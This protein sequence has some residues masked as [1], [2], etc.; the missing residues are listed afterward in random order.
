[1]LHSPLLRRGKPYRSLD[2]NRVPHHRTREPFVE[3]SQA[4]VG[5]LR[6]DL[7]GQDRA[8]ELLAHFTVDELTGICAAAAEHFLTGALP[9]G[10]ATQ[11]PEDYVLQVSAT[12]GMPH[13]MVRRNM[14]KISGILAQIRSVLAGLPRNLALQILDPRPAHFNR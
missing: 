14:Q 12:T 5:L 4:N 10:D 3:V 9:L 2:T 7:L 6:R 13:V 11:S 8:Q 1:M